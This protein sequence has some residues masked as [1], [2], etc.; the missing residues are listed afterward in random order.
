MIENPYDRRRDMAPSDFTATH[1]WFAQTVWDLPVGRHRTLL[2]GIPGIVN[3]AIGDWSITGV[4]GFHSGLPYSVTFS[5]SD[6]SG[7][8]TF[9]GRADLNSGCNPQLP[10]PTNGRYFDVSCF[11]IPPTGVGRF[12]T[13]PR[14]LLRGPSNWANDLSLAKPFYITERVDLRFMAQ[15]VNILNHPNF[16][17]PQ[18]NITAPNAGQIFANTTNAHNLYDMRQIFFHVKLEF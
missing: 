15:F 14:N 17:N 6:P 16:G 4:V 13:S 8:G 3:A 5:G 11:A 18:A 12:G 9:S 10:N 1:N 2:R 7:T